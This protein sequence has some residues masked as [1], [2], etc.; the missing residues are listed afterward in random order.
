MSLHLVDFLLRKMGPRPLDHKGGYI[1]DQRLSTGNRAQYLL[2]DRSKYVSMERHFL[3][4]YLRLVVATCHARG[5]L[6]TGGMAAAMLTP[7]ADENDDE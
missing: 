3:Q 7:G 5:A 2:P 1:T 6:A 4:S